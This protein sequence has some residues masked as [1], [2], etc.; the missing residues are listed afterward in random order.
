[1][2]FFFCMWCILAKCLKAADHASPCDS[3]NSEKNMDIRNF[4]LRKRSRKASE[5]SEKDSESDESS[6]SDG[7]D[8]K[9]QR[10]QQLTSK[11]TKKAYKARLS[12]RSL[13]ESKYPWV[14][15]NDV[16]NGMYCKLCQKFGKPPATARGAWT[17]RR[18][19]DWNHGTELLKLHN[20]SNWHKNSALTARMAEQ[21]SVLELQ[22]SSA[23]RSLNEK[24]ARNR[25]IVLKLLRSVY[26][27]VKHRI[28]HTTTFEDLVELQVANGDEFL[29]KHIKDGPGNAQYTSKFSITSLIEAIGTWL[30]E[31]LLDSL[32]RSP[33][34]SLLADECEDISTQEEL[35]ICC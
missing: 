11:A 29:Q 27:L 13:W 7:S 32:K 10:V 16:K 9:E 25:M 8:I 17:T 6:S 2:L 14:Y 26:F 20:E 28:P 22:R 4:M 31:R 15:C 18:I 21:E 30:D 5:E 1:M 33:F 35:S 23:M 12:Y 24:K 19:V 3:W 34:F